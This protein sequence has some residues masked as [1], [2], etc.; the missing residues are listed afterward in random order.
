MIFDGMSTDT[1]TDYSAVI[2]WL[3][4][5]IKHGK[6][7]FIQTL[8]SWS[9]WLYLNYNHSVNQKDPLTA[10]ADLIREFSEYGHQASVIS[11]DQLFEWIEDHYPDLD[12]DTIE[13]LVDGA[14]IDGD[15]DINYVEYSK[16]VCRQI[17]HLDSTP[18]KVRRLWISRTWL[19]VR[20][21]RVVVFGRSLT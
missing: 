10:E 19:G 13:L 17:L 14:D 1:I 12:E 8:L 9:F 18:L 4:F 2:Q 11:A 7:V 16:L 20:G 21:T 5:L 3:G 15:G 6:A